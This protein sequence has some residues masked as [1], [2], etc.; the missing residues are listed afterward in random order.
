M[1]RVL[2]N[3]RVYEEVKLEDVEFSKQ[4]FVDSNDQVEARFLL[5]T[6]FMERFKKSQ[7][8]LAQNMQ[9][10]LLKKEKS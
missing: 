6:A 10:V 4:F 9:N 3:R 1:Q 8:P 5:T 2:G 7:I